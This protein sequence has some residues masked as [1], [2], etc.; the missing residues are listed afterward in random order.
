MADIYLIDGL[1]V[2][3]PPRK[4]ECERSARHAKEDSG[5]CAAPFSKYKSNFFPPTSVFSLALYPLFKTQARPSSLQ[6]LG[7]DGSGIPR[8]S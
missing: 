6:E 8:V 7:Q 3:V 2:S 4:E 5:L 1:Q